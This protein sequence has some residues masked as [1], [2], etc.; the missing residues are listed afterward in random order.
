MSLQ[1]TR[2]PRIKINLVTK[3]IPGPWGK[4]TEKSVMDPK[5]LQS[6]LFPLGDLR[7]MSLH[8]NVSDPPREILQNYKAISLRV[9]GVK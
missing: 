6:T 2:L 8:E 3:N 9:R 5:K 7:Q 1:E 4:D